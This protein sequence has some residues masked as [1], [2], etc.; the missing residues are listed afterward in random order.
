MGSGTAKTVNVDP[1]NAT[2]S[3]LADAINNSGIGVT[4]VVNSDWNDTV[5][6]VRNSGSAGTLTVNSSILDTTDTSTANLNYTNSSDI[7]GL[8]NL[9]ITMST[10]YD[11]TI[12]SIPRY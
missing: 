2:L 11:G 3:G 10:N 5:V 4:A 9:G 1:S 12:L 8:A 7:S 6:S